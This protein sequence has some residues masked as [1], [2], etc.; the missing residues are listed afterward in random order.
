MMNYQIVQ[1]QE[2][3][4]AGFKIRTN[5]QSETMG[6]QIG[7]LWQKFYNEAVSSIPGQVTGYGI[8]LYTNYAS[9]QSGDYDMFACCEVTEKTAL[10]EQFETAVIPAGRYAEFVVY[11]D[12]QHDVAAFW[13]EL[14]QM[15]L[16][17]SFT[18]DFEEYRCVDSMGNAQ[19]HIYIALK[20]VP[21]GE[22]ENGNCS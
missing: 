9:D 13:A 3:K 8:G 11:G 17:R 6:A 12:V 22:Q 15:P 20:D 18:G 2:K 14:W 1:L 19:I 16:H 5:N 10:P 4:V 21:K 7:A